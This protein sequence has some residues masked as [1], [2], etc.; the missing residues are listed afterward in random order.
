MSEWLGY[1]R[2]NTPCPSFILIDRDEI[3]HSLITKSVGVK[4]PNSTM[5]NRNDILANV[6]RCVW[7]CCSCSRSHNYK[8]DSIL[9]LM[10]YKRIRQPH[11]KSKEEKRMK[12]LGVNKVRKTPKGQLRF[13]LYGTTMKELNC[14][15]GDSIGFWKDNSGRIFLQ[16]V[17]YNY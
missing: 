14:K 6:N 3:Q 17:E 5:V 1:N 7:L 16:K 2:H 12:I 10:C 15:E 13:T 8:C 11:V 9:R 4:R